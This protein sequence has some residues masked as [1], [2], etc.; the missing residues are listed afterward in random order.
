MGCFPD[1]PQKEARNNTRNT[2]EKQ[3]LSYHSKNGKPANGNM[4]LSV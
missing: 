4:S 2:T 1:K 3:R